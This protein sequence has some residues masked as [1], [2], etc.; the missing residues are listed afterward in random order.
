M[1]YVLD[2]SVAFKWEVAEVDSDKAIRLRDGGRQGL[3]RLLAP[4]AFPNEIA[5][6]LTR[7]ERQRRITPAQ[8]AQALAGYLSDLPILH[9]SLPLLPKAYAISS[10]TRQGLHDCLYVVL[11][12]E[13]G[14]DLV[15][16]D[17]KLRKN[18]G[19]IFPFIIPLSSLP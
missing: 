9:Q 5:H 4:D 12:Q 7:A 6:A 10:A 19:S 1:I 17:D 8:G 16:A 11:A 3:H 18:L 15:T 14:C 2:S 13:E